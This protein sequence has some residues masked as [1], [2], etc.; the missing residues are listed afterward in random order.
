MKQIIYN[1]IEEHR[2]A[3]WLVFSAMR[4]EALAD[5]FMLKPL[6]LSTASFRILMIL[7][8]LG[9]QAPSEIIDLLGSSKSN[10]AQRLSLLSRHS[11]IELSHK[12]GEDKRRAS[13]R[14]TPLGLQRLQ[15]ARKMFKKHNLHIENYFS[16]KEMQDF[17]RLT[18]KLNEGLDK[19]EISIKKYYEENKS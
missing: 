19:C 15:S 2:L 4:L 7:D 14:I 6:G 11:F 8:S 9:P 18:R 5:R 12:T 10:L 1:Q 3:G 16:A 17:L 13:A